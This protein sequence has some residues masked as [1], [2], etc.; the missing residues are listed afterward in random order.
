MTKI[1]PT[2]DKATKKHPQHNY[3]V[4]SP[5]NQDPSAIP[6][7]ELELVNIDPEKIDPQSNLQVSKPK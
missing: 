3:A 5:D 7:E 4:N 6:P 1:G 2:S